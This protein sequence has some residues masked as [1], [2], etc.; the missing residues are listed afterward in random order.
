MNKIRKIVL[1]LITCIVMVT[2]VNAKSTFSESEST[3]SEYLSENVDLKDTYSRFLKV[4]ENKNKF[5]TYGSPNDTYRLGGL[6]SYEEFK[7]TTRKKN[8][9]YSYLFESDEYWTNTMYGTEERM[10]VSRNDKPVKPTSTPTPKYGTRVTE[11]VKN[12]TRV[13]GTGAFSDPWIFEPQFNVTLKSNNPSRGKI[14]G[15]K[16]ILI[17]MEK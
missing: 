16:M 13:S 14:K 12:E 3:A 5:Y 15:E 7:I 4:V 8:N 9:T 1:C 6:L 17:I 11:Y 2:T 10:V